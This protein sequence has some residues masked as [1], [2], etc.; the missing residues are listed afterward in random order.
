MVQQ[1]QR[2]AVLHAYLWYNIIS[3]SIVTIRHYCQ[4]DWVNIIY[5]IIVVND[6]SY[7]LYVYYVFRLKDHIY[8]Y[9]QTYFILITRFFLI[10]L[11]VEIS[12]FIFRRN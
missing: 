9:L 5:N 1:K 11:F 6:L 12:R 8:F 10:F 2:T 3:I 4:T 7:F